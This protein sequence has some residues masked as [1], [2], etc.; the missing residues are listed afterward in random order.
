MSNGASVLFYIVVDLLDVYSA[1]CDFLMGS[2]WVRK[3]KQ[4]LATFWGR[5][6][7]FFDKKLKCEEIG[8][9]SAASLGKQ[10]KALLLSD[11]F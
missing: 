1:Q 7:Y 8:F 6:K 9:Y 2:L 11:I 3:Q 5:R 10:R 4:K